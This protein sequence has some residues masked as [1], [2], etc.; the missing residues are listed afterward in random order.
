METKVI[1][2]VEQY[3]SEIQVYPEV[4]FFRGQSSVEYKLLPS[5]GRLFKNGNE[6]ALVEYERCIF[7]EFKR[8]FSQYTDCRPQRDLDFLFLAQHYGLPTR[9][10]DWTYNPIIA[11]YFA[12]NSNFEKD[13]VVFQCFPFSHAIFNKETHDIFSFPRESILIPDLT[14]M[15]YK[16]QNG[17]FVLYPKP[18]IESTEHISYKFIIPASSKRIILTKLIKIGI[19]ESFIMP[20]LDSLCKDVVYSQN[21]RYASYL[22]NPIWG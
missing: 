22:K 19:T 12:C 20:S 2:T 18:W 14:D 4:D 3:L 16:N 6:Q 7:D 10:L 11:L 13:G 9:L 8:K 15:R 1:H 5:I 21:L 17:L